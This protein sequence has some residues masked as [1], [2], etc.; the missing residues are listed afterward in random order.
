MCGIAG[1]IG[2]LNEKLVASIDK[3]SEAMIHR[4]PDGAGKWLSNSNQGSG[5]IFTHRRLAIIDLSEQSAQPMLDP[6]SQCVIT[7]NGEL[8]NYRSLRASLINKGYKFSSAGDTE[9]ILKSYVEWGRDCVNHFEGMFAFAIYDPDTQKIFI[10]RDPHGI[11]PLYYARIGETPAIA[12]FI[13]ASE[14]KSLLATGLIPRDLNPDALS[15]YLWNGFVVE[16]LTMVQNVHLLEA[17]HTLTVDQDGVLEDICYWE[18]NSTRKGGNFNGSELDQG[19]I[20]QAEFEQ[21]L[22]EIVQNH[23]ISDVPVGVFLSGGVDSSVVA[24]LAARGSEQPIN[25]FCITFSESEFSESKYAKRVAQA[26]GS[27]HHEFLLTGEYFVEHLDEALASLDQ[28]TF[29]GINTYYVSRAVAGQNIK[30][31]L[32]GTGGDELFG[33]YRSFSEIPLIISWAKLLEFIPVKLRKGLASG[34]LKIMQGRQ[35]LPIQTRWGKLADLLGS[36]MSS[37]SAYQV[38]YSLFTEK[39]LSCLSPAYYAR[40]KQG[41]SKEMRNRLVQSASGSAVLRDVSCMEGKLFLGQRLLR[42]SDACSMSV[43]L[44]LRVPLVGKEMSG[45]VATLPDNIRFSSHGKKQPLRDAV[46]RDLPVDIFNRP[47]RGFELPMDTWLKTSLA[48]RGKELF[49]DRALLE[50]TGL[51]AVAV[52]KLWLAYQA[53]EK[54]LYWSRIWSLYVLLWWCKTNGVKLRS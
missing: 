31:A 25:T 19:I 48:S 30:V 3:A 21:K 2:I 33:G 24:T 41:L 47:K 23:L 20:G 39:F 34:M 14:L 6:D 42:D 46:S 32:A 43:S 12:S 40:L 37:I 7:Y 4:G 38:S 27:I 49:F 35:S 1:A 50:E 53:G 28:P 26:I 36:D 5:V 18:T 11:K 9:V 15:S 54:G 52:R 16:P 44:E 51:D 22:E 10:A 29:D 45:L 8:Y 17:G 13:F